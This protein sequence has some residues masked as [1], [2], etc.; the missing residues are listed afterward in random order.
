MILKNYTEVL[1][2]DVMK[3]LISNYPEICKC[4]KCQLDMMAVALNNLPAQYIVS[5]DNAIYLKVINSETQNRVDIIRACVHAI[6]LVSKNPRDCMNSEKI[7][8]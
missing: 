2:E 1:V 7:H 5:E 8:K 6:N 3:D 4:Q